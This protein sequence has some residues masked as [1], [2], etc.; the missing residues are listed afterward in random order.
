MS[1]LNVTNMING[2]SL[3]QAM[4]GP[5]LLMPAGGKLSILSSGI[6]DGYLLTSSEMD[7]EQLESTEAQN[8][9]DVKGGDKPIEFAIQVEVS[10]LG[11]GSDPIVVSKQW[12]RS[13]GKSYLFFVG[14]LPLS[15]SQ[16]ILKSVEL[17]F[18]Y[19]DT[20]SDGSPLRCTLA[21]EFAEDTVLAVA[22]K[23]QEEEKSSDGA[24]SAAK[25][26]SPKAQG[27][28][29]DAEKLLRETPKSYGL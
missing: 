27:S 1:L 20:A 16:F 15:T 17:Y 11:T 12:K 9:L 22:Q 26:A 4:W 29:I 6:W 3:S 25:K 2:F 18:G 19:D 5:H 10:K 21:L 7:V 28:G 24:S 8:P 13:L 23:K 14:L